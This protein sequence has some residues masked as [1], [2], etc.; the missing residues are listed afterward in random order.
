V[1]ELGGHWELEVEAVF[2]EEM[3]EGY[4]DRLQQDHRMQEGCRKLIDLG[5]WDEF[6]QI[7][8]PGWR[9]PA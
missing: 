4:E 7:F 6:V 3:I 8:R 1:V 9:S 5:A 2:D